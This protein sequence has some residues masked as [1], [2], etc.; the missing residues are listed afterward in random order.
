LKAMAR[1]TTR[2]EITERIAKI[3]EVI[4][5]IA[6]RTSLIT[7]FPGEKNK[8][9]MIMQEF[10]KEIRFDRL[11]VFTYSREEGTKAAESSG[12]VLEIVKRK[13]KNAIMKIQQEIAFEKAQNTAGSVVNVMIEGK[14]VKEDI[15]VGRTY[16]DAPGVDGMIFVE[17]ERE[18][19]SGDFVKVKVTGSKDYDLVG[20]I[21][22]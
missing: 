18:L 4:P 12:Q 1:R 7:G 8:D 16:K 13:R 15:Y 21:E 2:A 6:L 5:D 3:R 11:G 20:I 19:L 17:S 22:D 10:V 14:L 9:H